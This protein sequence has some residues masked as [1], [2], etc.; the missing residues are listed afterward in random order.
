M[1]SMSPAVARKLAS[2]VQPGASE[3]H[4]QAAISVSNILGAALFVAGCVGFYWPSLY[5]L[6]VT[7]FLAGSLLFLFS[8][9]AVPRLEHGPP[10]P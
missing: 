1:A 9:L 2:A 4:Q 8:A 5:V 6:S 7:L 10:T 3:L